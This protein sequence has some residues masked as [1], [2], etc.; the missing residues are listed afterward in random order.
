MLEAIRRVLSG[1]FY[2][3]DKMTRLSHVPG[4]WRRSCVTV[5][6]RR[7]DTTK[8]A[9]GSE[10]RLRWYDPTS[11]NYAMIASSEA[12]A[13]DRSL[14]YPSTR[15]ADGFHDWVLVADGN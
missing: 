6:W 8:I 7:V 11:G 1:Q 3:S 13:S 2:V 14:S 4:V 12:K 15:H 9:K 10:V 5:L